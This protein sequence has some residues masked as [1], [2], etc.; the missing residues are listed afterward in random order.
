MRVPR[1]IH[2]RHGKNFGS[3]PRQIA[4]GRHVARLVD[5]YVCV[6]DDVKTQCLAEGIAPTRLL[7]ILNGID[8]GRFAFSGPR[9]GGP[10]IAVARLSP[11]K[12]MANLVR[13][14]AIAATQEPGLRVEIAG[15]GPCLSSLRRLASD[16]GVE[17][18]VIFLGEVRDVRGLLGRGSLF[19]LPSRSEGTSLTLLEAMACGLPTLATRVG[20]N[21][22]VILEEQTGRL[23][24]PGDPSALAQAVIRI[25][26]D[27]EGG[28]R[29][30][31]AGRKRVE[32]HFEIQRMVTD[33]ESLYVDRVPVPDD[34][35]LVNSGSRYARQ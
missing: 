4:I 1:L 27:P 24:P 5:R 17:E 11:E 14:V 13:S 10:I 21:P 20:G 8:V 25:Q 12:D 16:L 2:T 35:V 31:S 22:E 9:R 18:R 23:V 15:N 33:Y 28:L 32:Q 29:M 6:S 7:T 19:V 3:T 26:R 30:G 34:G